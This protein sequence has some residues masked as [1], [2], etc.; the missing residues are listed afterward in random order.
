MYESFIKNI[1]KINSEFTTLDP[2]KKWVRVWL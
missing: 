2:P 1:V